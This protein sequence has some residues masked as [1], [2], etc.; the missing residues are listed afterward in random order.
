MAQ[1]PGR[2]RA[3]LAALANGC[4]LMLRKGAFFGA[5]VLGLLSVLE[6][7][8]AQSAGAV[9]AESTLF[10]IAALIVAA[11]SVAVAAMALRNARKA[12]TDFLRFSRSIEMALRDLSSRSERDAA[13]IGELNRKIA[14][15]IE[16]LTGMA[17]AQPQAAEAPSPFPRRA[18]IEA[19]PVAV[20]PAA[21]RAPEAEP[22][23]SEAIRQALASA[24]AAGELEV[25]LQP[26]ISVAQGAATGF[27]VHA[28]V[29]PAEGG[30]PL[31][32]RRMAQPLPGLDQA[33]FEAALVR[34]AVSA[35]RRQL[36]T[37]SERMP[38]HIAISD[39]LLGSRAEVD[40][41]AELAR[42][43]RGLPASLVFSVPATLLA[44]GG[45]T[46]DRLDQLTAAGFRLAVEGWE[47]ARAELRDT[48]ARG[49]HFLKIPVNR[50]LDRERG[51]RRQLP[52]AELAEAAAEAGIAV[53]ATGVVRD[54]DA[55]GLI[56]L[57]IDLMEGE[58]FSG[59]RRVRS[60]AA[61]QA[62]L[63]AGM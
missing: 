27:E 3:A 54:D 8:R 42:V 33:A 48:R 60:S 35:S 10:P 16:T 11:I 51:R 44:A 39:A 34:S 28:H 23:T 6:A 31:D 4:V 37:A 30:K 22:A 24:V 53:I 56:D 1:D 52:G 47:G 46:R 18:E 41:I 59:P 36:G 29:E 7:S 61:R 45:E 55:V 21:E 50:L 32:I 13:S 49:A 15:E 63:A 26:I 17:A 58:R 62:A 38:F 43:H 19:R 9:A 40:A 5:V 14:E 57:G 2:N 25:S 12:Q 20:P